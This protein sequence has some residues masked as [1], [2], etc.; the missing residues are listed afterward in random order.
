MNL[1]W[2]NVLL[3]FQVIEH[4]IIMHNL[5]LTDHPV[6]PGDDPSLICPRE[7]GSEE[8]RV[9]VLDVAPDVA[10][11]SAPAIDSDCILVCYCYHIIV[12]IIVVVVL[13][14]CYKILITLFLSSARRKTWGGWFWSGLERDLSQKN[15][16]YPLEKREKL[17]KTN[18]WNEEGVENSSRGKEKEREPGGRK[19]KGKFWGQKIWR[20]T[21]FGFDQRGSSFFIFLFLYFFI[22]LF[23]Y[24]F[25]S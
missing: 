11:L 7:G 22:S 5:S 13:L 9:R 17:Q 20:E 19:E 16:R 8:K 3:L 1:T 2:K 21:G 14:S 15:T 24:F 23:L 18:K 12:I 6:S 25:I 10:C 4:N